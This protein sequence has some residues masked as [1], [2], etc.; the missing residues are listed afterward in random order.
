MRI[1]RAAHQGGGEDDPAEV[2]RR[3]RLEAARGNPL[4]NEREEVDLVRRPPGYLVSAST[5]EVIRRH[6]GVVFASWS[7]NAVAD[8]APLYFYVDAAGDCI[9]LER[10]TET[11][12]ELVERRAR[13][14]LARA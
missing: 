6:R 9:F 11:W 14:R 4:W 8:R 1:R 12:S 7:A 10:F 3:A 13:R 2:V 5:D